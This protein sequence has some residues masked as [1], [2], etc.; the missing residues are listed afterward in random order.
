MESISLGQGQG[1]KAAKLI[2]TAQAQ[3]GWVVLQVIWCGAV[4]GNPLQTPSYI[5]IFANFRFLSH[6]FPPVCLPP[7]ELPPGYL[8][9]DDPGADLRAAVRG[10]HPQPVQA[11][12]HLLP[13]ATVPSGGAA[14]A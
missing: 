12:A 6:P 4:Q 13:L 14:G 5:S 9:D 2:E 10:Q 1:P 7:S 3:G 11:M 8:L